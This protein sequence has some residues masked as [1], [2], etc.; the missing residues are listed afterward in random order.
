M[1]ET[2]KELDLSCIEM[3]PLNNLENNL[4]LPFLLDAKS[5]S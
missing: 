5:H 4:L 3:C 2:Y 1:F